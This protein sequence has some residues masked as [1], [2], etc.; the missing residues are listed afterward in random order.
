MNTWKA[1]AAIAAVVWPG[2]VLACGGHGSAQ[3]LIVSTEWLAAHLKD[4]NVVVLAVGSQS[5][6]DEG[7]IPGSVYVNYQEV[8]PKG[9]N[10][11]S[12][13]L[14]PMPRLAELF[15]KM[16]VSTGSRVIVYRLND[17][18]T[19]AARVVVTLDAMGMGQSTSLLDG[20]MREWNGEGR[21]VSKDAP[22]VKPGK[23]EPCPQS[24]VIADLNFVSQ[25]LKSADVRI[26][27]ARAPEFYQGTS[28][29]PG[30]VPG[31]ILG[32]SNVYF[33]SLFDSAGKLLPMPKLQAQFTA[34]GVKPGDVVVS[35]C[36]IGQQ[37]SALYVVSRYLG[38]DTR[39]YDGSW[40]EWSRHP[41]LPTAKA[42]Q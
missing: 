17:T 14:P 24:D 11:L 6:Y 42:V 3:T 34:A 38:Y 15:G 5:D 25:N 32:A 8:A 39:L 33:N 16:G 13:E 26:V 9:T 35:Y 12:A 7:H 22:A 41:G 23:L 31:H 19:Q 1:V 21:T 2:L 36:F 40:E 18:L 10:G 27:D 30:L 29:R 20:S 37:A 4:P 28:S